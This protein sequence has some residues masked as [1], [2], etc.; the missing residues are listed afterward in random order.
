[1][2]CHRLVEV[3]HR[4]KGK[5]S[6]MS[7]PPP[8]HTHYIYIYPLLALSVLEL[9][10]ACSFVAIKVEWGHQKGLAWIDYILISDMQTHRGQS[11]LFQTL[12]ENRTGSHH[13]LI[14]SLPV[15]HLPLNNNIRLRDRAPSPDFHLF[16]Q[17]IISVKIDL[18]ENLDQKGLDF[19]KASQK[20]RNPI[21]RCIT[22][23]SK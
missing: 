7:H 17:N 22:S 11:L 10:M 18:F 6:W 14:D 3:C 23:R 13:I 8:L 19:S 16:C 5:G 1:M 9:V 4:A 2:I 15:R 12:S 21:I 20:S